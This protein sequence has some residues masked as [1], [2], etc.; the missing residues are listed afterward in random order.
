MRDV[1]R[2]GGLQWSEIGVKNSVIWGEQCKLW[3]SGDWRSCGGVCVKS[4]K[5]C[6]LNM[7]N[8]STHTSA[9]E[10]STALLSSAFRSAAM[11]FVDGLLP[12]VVSSPRPPFLSRLA[13]QASLAPTCVR[14]C[15]R[16][17][18]SLS[19]IVICQSNHD[20]SEARPEQEVHQLYS[21][22]Q[23]DRTRCLA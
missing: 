7:R 14:A 5:D 4:L 20:T 1:P 10:G 18:P 11:P 17:L 2:W 16:S 19:S 3:A 8:A 21:D 13:R 23:T 6:T 12:G 15:P 9:T 22:E